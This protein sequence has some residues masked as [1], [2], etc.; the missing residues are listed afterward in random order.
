MK[1]VRPGHILIRGSKVKPS[2][3][4][5]NRLEHMGSEPFTDQGFV[6]WPIG[7]V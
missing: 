5:C 4:F 2:I 1:E 3:G 6:G 7:K